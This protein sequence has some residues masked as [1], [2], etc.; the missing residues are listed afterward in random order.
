M[1]LI[2]ICLCLCSGVSLVAF[3]RLGFP[4][5]PL[6][7]LRSRPAADRDFK[8][9][10]RL[11]RPRPT[12]ILETIGGP[13][14]HDEVT[15]TATVEEPARL[16]APAASTP[17]A[18]LPA[19]ASVLAPPAPAQVASTYAVAPMSERHPA[20]VRARLLVRETRVAMQRRAIFARAATIPHR[21]RMPQLR[22]VHWANGSTRST[23]P[24]PANQAFQ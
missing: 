2:I 17:A 21:P 11:A 16:D 14:A 6:H 12:P 24:E 19:K 7:I 13:A 20:A 4:E 8:D 9:Q 15:R 5:D 23:P 3:T 1:R 10:A 18:P 22:R